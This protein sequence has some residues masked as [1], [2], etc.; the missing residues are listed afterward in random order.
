MTNKKNRRV[1]AA[2]LFAVSLNVTFAGNVPVKAK[3]EPFDLSDVR[4]L[5]S[6]FKYA[7][8]V[9]QQLLLKMDVDRL[10]YPF[11]R[12]A[13]IPS[14][15]KGPDGLKF[16]FTGHVAGHFLSASAMI[17][18]NTGDNELKKKADAVVAVL[19]ECQANM[20]G[21]YLG[22]F[23]EK[24]I[25]Q[26][27][28]L[29]KDPSVAANVPW[30]CLHKIYA[31]LL[32]MYL[33]GNN[34]LALDVLLKAINWVEK[35][36]DQ[37][38]DEKMQSMLGMEHGGMN[39]LLANLYAVTRDEKHLRLAERFTHQ[40]VIL[41]FAKGVDLVDGHHANTLIPKFVGAARLY[42]FGGDEG[43]GKAAVNFW[44]AVI[45]DRTYATGGNSYYEGFSPRGF[46][47]DFVGERSTETCNV[48]N[49]LK[50]TRDLF[51]LDPKA[52]YADYYERALI[53][54]I[55]ST[56]NPQTG[57]Q[58]YFQLLQSGNT[59]GL[60]AGGVT[61]WRFIFN[62]GPNTKL[63]GTESQCCQG[64]GLESNAK[65]PNSIYFHSGEKE[66]Y[67]NLFIPSVLDWKD[68]MLIIR[69]ETRF[70]E[71]GATKL[72]FSCKKPVPFKLKIRRPWW[73]TKKFQIFVNGEKQTFVSTPGSYAQIERTWTNGDSVEVVMPMTLR[74]EGFKDN[75]KRASVMY[76]PLVMAGVT[77]QGNPFSVIKAK[78][79]SFLKTLKPIEG[80][81]LLF[82]GPASI[83]RI[84]P[85]QISY[86]PVVFRPLY[87]NF[88]Q[89]YA[90]F[91][92]IV[93]PENFQKMAGQFGAE[94]RLQQELEPHTVDMVQCG[95]SKEMFT[96]QTL[97]FTNKD[98]MP[99]SPQQV[100]ENQHGLKISEAPAKLF[101]ERQEELRAKEVEAQKSP[102]ALAKPRIG[103][104]GAG[105]VQFLASKMFFNLNG[106]F[107]SLEPGEWC[108]YQL[109]TLLNKKQQLSVRLWKAASRNLGE[110]A[111]KQGKLEILVDGQ[112][113]GTCDVETFPPGRFSEVTCPLPPD[114]I[115][116]KEKVEVLLRVPDNSLPVYGIYECR[117]LSK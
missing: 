96:F 108:S 33:L 69:Q 88:D 86:K 91:W 105:Y 3:A 83:F 46:L 42:E 111:Q 13:K 4:L 11:R 48:Y 14:P 98:W 113:M 81:P 77:E 56:R 66:L 34:K 70:P 61:G 102:D 64:T 30:Y 5:E 44:N 60:P 40:K 101:R 36:T 49:M 106:N 9:D 37:L 87:S 54:Q 65:Y 41:P 1:L 22:G 51:C 92:D 12:E 35:N 103:R 90:I 84:S 104:T 79:D 100:G 55:L 21:G 58:L 10:L 29:I 72:L 94:V 45:A 19:A 82:E 23:P 110:W 32:D 6:P 62:E 109:K 116:N 20:G 85:L 97:L 47:A 50:L 107:R 57:G 115:R 59:K 17:I 27:E 63:Y 53:N 93:T 25:L 31:G 18:R 75:P 26:L 52:S 78:D 38:S 99:R 2:A 117:I 76:G 24:S 71:E 15:A 43:M 95:R 73:A 28:G 112:V 74:I 80:K 7:Q 67:V 39:E 8:D 68:N 89:P 114:L 16:D